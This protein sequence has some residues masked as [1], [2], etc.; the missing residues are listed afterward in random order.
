MSTEPQIRYAQTSDGVN[1]AYAVVGSGPLLL[2]LRSF[3][4][5]D[6]ATEA[7][8]EQDWRAPWLD[9]AASRTVVFWDYRG[10]GLSGAAETHTLES[11]ILDVQSVVDAIGATCFDVLATMTPTH[12]AIA[13]AARYP[14]RIRRMVLLY[15]SHPG[16]SPRA[17]A[18]KL[19]DIALTHFRHYADL[20]ALR[21]N[22]W[23]SPERARRLADFMAERYTGETWTR[24]NESIEALDATTLARSV[25]APTLIIVD[26]NAPNR[27][28]AERRQYQRLLATTIPNAQLS[29]GKK[30]GPA[31][32]IAQV[33]AFLGTDVPAIP[34]G[35]PPSG[36]AVILFTDIV[37]STALT[38]RMGDAAFRDASRRVDD[39]V[40]AAIRAADGTP[41]AGKVLGDGVMGVFASAAQAIAAARACAALGELPMHIGVHAGDVIREQDNVYGG[42]VN[43][44]SRI[45]GLS[46]PGEILVSDVVRGMARSS[47]GVEFEDRGEQEMKGVG[48][49][50]RVYAVRAG[51]A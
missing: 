1:I 17:A 9:M 29:I 18:A 38:E 36:T 28:S 48:E 25:T 37:S 8:E 22:G 44:A 26:N 14:E 46:A 43:I 6:V 4:A 40:R 21:Q 15:A 23:G 20:F 30:G 3:M 33:D 39:G 5:P 34:G 41:V 12:F 11:G 45:C 50:V 19:P 24:L 13:Y 42:T 2:V 32:N 7:G 10:S 47:A 27:T 35:G 16:G 31:A 51:G 49:P